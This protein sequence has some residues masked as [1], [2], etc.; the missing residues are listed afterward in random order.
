MAFDIY[1][2]ENNNVLVRDLLENVETFNKVEINTKTSQGQFDA[3]NKSSVVQTAIRK[4]SD[5]FSH[6][7][8]WA[9]D[10]N[11]K[12]IINNGVV[13]NDLKLLSQ[14]NEYQNFNCFNNHVES[15]VCIYGI[16]YVYKSKIIGINKFNYYIIPF[17]MV[18]PVYSNTYN[19]IFEKEI[20]YY[21]IN[22]GSGALR[23]ETDDIFIYRDNWYKN[24]QGTFGLS[25]LYSLSEP[26]S[27]LLS[28]GET[29]TQLI[30][31][32]GARG[33]IGQGAK[34]I[35]TYS[36]PFLTREKIELQKALKEYGGLRGKFKYIITKGAASYIP[37]T[38]KIVD[39]QLPELLMSAK[40]SVFEQYGLPNIFAA[41]ETRY[42][43]LP[44][45]RKEFYT[46][47]IIP[48]ATKRFS[49][50]CKMMSI[51]NRDWEYK[52]DW[53]HLDFYQEDLKESAIALQQVSGAITP[54]VDKGI[55]T[56]EQAKGILEPYLY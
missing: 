50:F 37:I 45:A 13:K 16:C 25:R 30:V 35:D 23:L 53:S 7:E 28:I 24:R 44:E 22:T 9:K 20:L 17:D 36:A 33:I 26:I 18:S 38:S 12:K 29:I 42:K 48:E 5:A 55:I 46:G 49:D 10:D 40:I 6:L 51:T 54:L 41:E 52:P 15:Q 43:S 39:M 8:I 56:I 2:S 21:N 47:T 31:D 14:P 34:D 1:A 4:R 32:G 27:T 3:F 19:S 11:G